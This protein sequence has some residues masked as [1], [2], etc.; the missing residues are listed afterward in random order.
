MDLYRSL[1]AYA[2]RER[3][4]AAVPVACVG[5][6]AQWRLRCADGKTFL[7]GAE[8]VEIVSLTGTLSASGAHLHM[9]LARADLSVLG[10]HL[11][12]GCIV[13]TTTEIVLHTVS[14]V[15]FKRSFDPETGFN[16]LEIS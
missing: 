16:E 4:E 3:L 10:G 11:R 5:S 2:E 15:M 14:D 13:N 7:E 1:R 12:E 9:S 8:P 6:L